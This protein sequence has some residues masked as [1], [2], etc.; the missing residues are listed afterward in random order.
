MVNIP[1]K[2]CCGCTACASICPSSAIAMQPDEEGFLYPNVDAQ[3]CVCC[4]LC[5][6]VCPVLKPVKVPEEYTGCYVAQNLCNDVLDSSTSGGFIDALYRYILVEQNGFGV[7]VAFDSLFYPKHII[8]NS[9]EDA[10]SFRNSK[11]A[12]SDLNT[13]F[14]EVREKLSL[15]S[16]VIFVGTPC[17]VAGLKAFL[18]YEYDNLITVDLVCRSVPSPKLWRK[19]LDWQEKRHGLKIQQITCRKKTYG[20]HS[21]TL[22][23]KFA[24]GESY[25]GSNRVDYFMK[26]FH[27]DICSRPSCYHCPFK[28]Q[29]RCSD[30]TVFDSWNPQAV[31]KQ[32]VQDNDR[33]FSNV[34]VHSEK[35][36]KILFEIKNVELYEADAEKMFAFTGGME[37]MSISYKK[38]R[39]TF[40]Q[41]L[42]T[43]G[44]Y[45]TVAKYVKVTLLDRMIESAKPIWYF[46]RKKEIIKKQR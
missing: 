41:D 34:L 26:S 25:S 36:R 14:S 18:G 3:R 9:Y 27:H 5:E 13:V 11:Y 45:K 39:E 28:T 33:G 10:K 1:V 7:G 12:Q 32:T 46:I 8:V 42:N 4:G 30:F 35:G 6:K 38:E 17:Q 16:C 43:K 37:R 40:Y 2:W 44:F 23:I 21:G 19:Y 29:H 20:Y 31:T 22:E 15:G 24:D